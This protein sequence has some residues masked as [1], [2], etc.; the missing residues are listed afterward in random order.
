M[1]DHQMRGV[2][3]NGEPVF[4]DPFELMDRGNSSTVEKRD[5]LGGKVWP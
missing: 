3:G 1:N 4:L 5:G 2:I